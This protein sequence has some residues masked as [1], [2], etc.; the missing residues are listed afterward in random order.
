[1]S[2]GRTST[3]LDIYLERDLREGRLD[4]TAAQ[5][6]IDDLVVKLRLVR[7]LRAT[8]VRI[9]NSWGTSWG[10][11]GFATLGW[12]FVESEVCEAEAAGTFPATILTPSG[13]VRSR[14]DARSRG[15]AWRSGGISRACGRRASR[16]LCLRRRRSMLRRK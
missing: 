2:L 9:E 3:F 8:G 6:L 1:M 14:A 10:A 12:D 15:R 16:R 4:E 5:E 7:F 13:S 11:G